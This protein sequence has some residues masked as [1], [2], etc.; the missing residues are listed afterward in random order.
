MRSSVVILGVE[1]KELSSLNLEER[2]N[3]RLEG[4]KHETPTPD[5]VLRILAILFPGNNS[6][7]LHQARMG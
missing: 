1:Q 7:N 3:S 5:N 4:E 6:I 2:E